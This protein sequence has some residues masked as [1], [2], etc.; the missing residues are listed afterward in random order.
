M[1]LQAPGKVIKPLTN[2]APLKQVACPLEGAKKRYG[3]PLYP[4]PDPVAS[5]MKS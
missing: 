2:T 1:A 3:V 5:R 4:L